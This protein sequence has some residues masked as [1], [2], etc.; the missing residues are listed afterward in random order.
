MK[1]ADGTPDESAGIDMRARRCPLVATMLMEPS[2]SS[3]RT[4]FRMGLLSSV[5][6]AKAVWW[7]NPWRSL[8]FTLHPCS[9]ST[10][11]SEGNSSAGSP[12]NLKLLRPHFSSI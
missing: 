5:D 11:G 10:E 8:P 4:P 12:L 1:S 3:H 2:C 6:T 7:I 9:K